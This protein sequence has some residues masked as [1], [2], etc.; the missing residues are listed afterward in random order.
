MEWW[1]I[2]SLIFL[3]LMVSFSTGIPVAFAFAGLNLVSLV[4][5][6]GDLRGLTLLMGSIFDSTTTFTLLAVP[7]FFLLGEVLFHSRVIDMVMDATDKWVGKVRAR[8]LFVSLGA[9]TGLATLSGAGM[10]DTA[11]IAS[12]LFPDMEKRGYDRKLS[13]GVITSAGL[14]AAMIPPSALAVL[15]AA[16]A[17]VSAGRLLMAGVFPGL[18]MASIYGVYIVARIH[19]NPSLAPTYEYQGVALWDKLIL[20]AKLLPLGLIIFMVMGFIILGI[21]TPGES[22]ATGALGAIVV[23]AIYG[24]LTLPVLGRA[25]AGVARITGMVILI[26]AGAQAFGQ[27]LSMTGASQQLFE[28]LIALDADPIVM[29]IVVQLAVVILGLFL[30]PIAIMLITIPILSPLIAEMGW[31][32][33]WFYLLFLMN[34]VIGNE[35]PPF[36]LTLFVVKGVLP[37]ISIG[38]IYRAQIPFILLDL[39]AMGL[40]IAFPQIALWLPGQIR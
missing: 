6:V 22:A 30:D 23:T 16:L 11:L 13:I 19:F 40:V 27:M 35:S 24:R 17:H 34:I 4:I 18:M 12:T 7:M 20:T 21:A 38:E 15:L 37:H 25:L 39:A 2:L 10:A 3:S 5:V 8:L 9:G 28:T 1:L 26:I 33:I 29:L 31:D 36:G 32:P 14:L